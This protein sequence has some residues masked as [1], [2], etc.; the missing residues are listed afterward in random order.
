MAQDASPAAQPNMFETTFVFEGEFTPAQEKEYAHLPFDMPDDATRLDVAYS[1]SNQIDSDPK[2]RGGN[3]IDLGVF[4]ERGIDFLTAGFRG[5]SGSERHEFFI[6]NTQATPGYLAGPLAPGRWHVGLGL[7][8]IAPEG[9]RYR[10]V[11]TITRGAKDNAQT[12]MH[13]RPRALPSSPVTLREGKWLRGEMHCH[14]I[15]SDGASTPAELLDTARTRGLDFLAITDHNSIRCQRELE[16]FSEPG[17]VLIRGVEVTTFKGHFNVW[18]IPDW[19]D[20]RVTRPEEMRAAIQFANTRGALT[21]CNHPKPFG[22]P[23]DYQAVDDYHCIEVWNGPWQINNQVSLDFWTNQLAQGKRIP[24]VGGSDWHNHPAVPGVPPRALGTPT[25]WVQV[26]GTPDADAILRAMRAGHV[27]LSDEPDGAWV[28][29][30]IPSQARAGD[31][32]EC[33]PNAELEAQVLC[34]RGAGNVLTLHDENGNFFRQEILTPE[35]CVTV[36][37]RAAAH[38]FVRAELRG[39]DNVMKA[40]TNPIYLRENRNE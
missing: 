39:H 20:F 26:D 27:A 4:D 24:A 2:L 18:G 16:T 7:Y 33:S 34:R 13:P 12:Q 40:L 36:R 6:S 15:H 23:W 35:Q 14:T 32:L 38:R 28:D 37:V 30:Q 1:Y 25:L 11:V 10:V 29:L 8:K 9:C 21:S 5:W 22:P 19:I 3:T 17:L 31:V